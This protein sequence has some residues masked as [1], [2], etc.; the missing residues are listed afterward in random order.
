VGSYPEGVSSY[1]CYDMAGNLW[2]WTA[3]IITARTGAEVG[4]HVNEIRGGSWY[5]TGNSCRSIGIG[6]GRAASGVYNTVGFRIVR[7]ALAP[8]EPGAQPKHRESL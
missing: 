5:A 3:T 7:N 4:K 2:N 1:G 6:E 8:L